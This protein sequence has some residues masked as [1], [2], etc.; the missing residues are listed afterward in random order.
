MVY[1][2]DRHLT[3]REP[4]KQRIL[5]KNVLKLVKREFNVTGYLQIYNR[6]SDDLKFR[7][8]KR[9]SFAYLFKITCFLFVHGIDNAESKSKKFLYAASVAFLDLFTEIFNNSRSKNV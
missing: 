2:Q 7:Y 1:S 4:K 8:R 3:S 6:L 5:V 9:G